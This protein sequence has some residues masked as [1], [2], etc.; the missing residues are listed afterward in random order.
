MV[1]ESPGWWIEP[2][3]CVVSQ[4]PPHLP[5]P[6][7]SICCCSKCCGMFW[8]YLW[9]PVCKWGS[10]RWPSSW[11]S[12]HMNSRDT[13]VHRS[14]WPCLPCS[15]SRWCIHLPRALRRTGRWV[16]QASWWESWELC[17]KH[18]EQGH[19]CCLK[20]FLTSQGNFCPEASYRGR[21]RALAEM[22]APGSGVLPVTYCPTRWAL[23][24]MP[25][26]RAAER[27]HLLG[28]AAHVEQTKRQLFPHSKD[29]EQFH[30]F[31]PLSKH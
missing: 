22:D 9:W 30:I 15:R 4:P 8:W 1:F 7:H 23:V 11:A 26:L 12:A 20:G 18:K 17:L 25:R 31:K 14:K 2:K 27:Q 24:H 29:K 10:K 13:C 5:S 19:S 28:Y 16:T 21:S 3:T 6:H